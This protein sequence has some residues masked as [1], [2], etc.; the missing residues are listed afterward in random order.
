MSATRSPR[1]AS[2]NEVAV[3]DTTRRRTV[4]AYVSRLSDLRLGLLTFV[5]YFCALIVWSLTTPVLHSPDEGAHVFRASAIANGQWLPPGDPATDETAKQLLAEKNLIVLAESAWCNVFVP[6]EPI[7]CPLVISDDDTPTP[8][9]SG[10]ARY[11]PPY[12]VAVG[13]V[14]NI[15]DSTRA[16]YAMRVMSAAISAAGIALAVVGARRLRPSGSAVVGVV[17]AATPM[18]TFLSGMVNPSAIELSWALPFWV[19]C[20]VFVLGREPTWRTGLVVGLSGAILASARTVSP[21]WVALIA[22]AC[23]AYGGRHAL[24][25]VF[26]KPAIAAIVP[27][28]ISA[29]AN[30]AWTIFAGSSVVVEYPD[31]PHMTANERLTHNID[32]IAFWGE[33]ILGRF[34]YLDTPMPGIAF[35]LLVAAIG[36]VVALNLHHRRALF[37]AIA[38]ALVGI[39][40]GWYAEITMLN[41]IGPWWQGRYTLPL[42]FG[43]ILILAAPAR[44]G[45]RPWGDVTVRRALVGAIAAAQAISVLG[46][47]RRF[48]VGL[49][50]PLF[51]ETGWAPPV[52]SWTVIIASVVVWLLIALLLGAVQTDAVDPDLDL[53]RAQAP[54]GRSAEDATT[55]PVEQSGTNPQPAPPTGASGE[56][57]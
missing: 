51:E 45:T 15:F 44:A 43:C 31:L 38:I 34:G 54:T 57:S 24:R 52:G 21:L 28:A 11:Y 16:V 6:A 36:T 9:W 40:I 56:S 5:L 30:G 32:L 49:D 29:L 2:E 37:F 20:L 27:V 13:W 14:D 39:A 8:I 22:L 48:A 41:T 42:W 25:R 46:V 47:L 23:I 50:Y 33:S 19:W 53:G 7:D 35:A 55:K 18:V 26:S 10:A 4:G 12:Y 17:L 1:G 3:D